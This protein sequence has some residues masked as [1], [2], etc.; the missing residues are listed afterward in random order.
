[1]AYGREVTI[2]VVAL[3]P[4]LLVGGLYDE[5]LP[6]PDLATASNIGL[7]LVTTSLLR[8]NARRRMPRIYRQ[9]WISG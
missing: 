5:T 1:M 2:V 3:Q 7:H 6:H 8:S 9:Q 4:S